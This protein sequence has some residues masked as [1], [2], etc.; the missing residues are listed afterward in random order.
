MFSWT[1]IW[2]RKFHNLVPKK[3]KQN[4]NSTNFAFN[5]NVYWNDRPTIDST[6][7]C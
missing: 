5:E 6:W 7:G 4:S 3:K 1:H 2:L